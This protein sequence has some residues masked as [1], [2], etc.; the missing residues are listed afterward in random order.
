MK[1][2]VL[3]GPRSVELREVPAPASEGMA[4]VR[5][6]TVG[7]CG[8]DVSI[9]NGKIP[10]DVP[11]VL[12]HE[13]V[14]RV[15]QPGPGTRR[16]VNARVLVNP[17]ISCG[18]C[19]RCRDDREHLCP[20]GALIGRDRDGGFAE[21]VAVPEGNLLAV[22]ETLESN[23]VALLQVLGTCVHAQQSVTAFPGQTAAVVGLGVAG[24][25]MVQLLR[26][27]GIA[28]VLGV[29][30]SPRKQD[31][32]RRLGASVAVGPDEARQAALDLTHGRGVDIVIEAV[33]TPATFAQAIALAGLGATVVMFGTAGKGADTSG[34]PLYD[35]YYKE[36]TVLNPRAAR[37]RDYARAIDLVTAGVVNLAPLCSASYPLAAA[38]DALVAA[39]DPKH[40]KITLELG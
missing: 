15:V 29:T 7:I 32:G 27:R 21:F 1:A 8:T 11:R 19:S 6:D 16:A 9:F 35:L 33:G 14:G 17:S 20:N 25:L 28:S 23:Q 5:V 36:L 12:G 13:L 26:A 4:L 40:L 22:P 2:V 37:H 18:Q 38:A 10:V 39:S 30:R 24:L 3:T 31:L 34:L